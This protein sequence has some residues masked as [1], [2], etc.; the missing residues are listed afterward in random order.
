MDLDGNL[1]LMKTLDDAWNSQDWDTFIKRH[2]ESAEIY[3]PGQPQPTVEGTTTRMNLYFSAFPD[4]VLIMIHTRY[5]L[6]KEIG[7]F[8]QTLLGPSRDR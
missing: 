6:V 8:Q 4:N 3:W 2:A 7:Q 1:K 5:Y